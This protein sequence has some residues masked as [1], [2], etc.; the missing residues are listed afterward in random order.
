M[1]KYLMPIMTALAL[2]GCG[3]DTSAPPAADNDIIISRNCHR[4]R[5]H[6]FVRERNLRDICHDKQFG[7]LL[8]NPHDRRNQL[9]RQDKRLLVY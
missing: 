8:R 5:E 3:A 6:R 2:S 1:K 9:F 4:N 7:D